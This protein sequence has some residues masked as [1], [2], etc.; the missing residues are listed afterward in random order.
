M[1]DEEIADD[2]ASVAHGEADAEIG[3]VPR[4]EGAGDEEH[5]ILADG[6]A[7]A[8]RAEHGKD[9]DVRE[10]A[11]QRDEHA[12]HDERLQRAAAAAKAHH[13]AM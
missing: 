4:G 7:E 11:E 3:H 10:P 6:R 9:S 1:V 2:D 8:C 13:R 12:L 5:Q